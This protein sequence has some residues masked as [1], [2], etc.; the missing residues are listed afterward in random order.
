MSLDYFG[1]DN[2]PPPPPSSE[3]IGDL[4]AY[5]NDTFSVK[6]DPLPKEPPETTTIHSL[7][8][9]MLHFGST[10]ER[11]SLE[12]ELS[13]AK[14]RFNSANSRLESLIRNKAD[15]MSG[16]DPNISDVKNEMA[17]ATTRIND[18]N[19]KLSNLKD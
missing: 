4:A 6:D 13:I 14:D 5:E 11:G 1:K 7:Y 16:V 15:G 2:P 19:Y 12:H 9:K 10:G 18:I 8:E 3:S 17:S